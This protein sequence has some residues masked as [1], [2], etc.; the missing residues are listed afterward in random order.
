MKRIDDIKSKSSIN[1][2]KENKS[3]ER[4]CQPTRKEDCAGDN[5]AVLL[6]LLLLLLLQGPMIDKVTHDSCQREWQFNERERERE[7]ERPLAYGTRLKSMTLDDRPNQ[8][9]TSGAASYVVRLSE[10]WHW[11]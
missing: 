6:L 3:K 10:R 11:H 7:R 9:S 5:F 8:L 4:N 2:S 1:Q